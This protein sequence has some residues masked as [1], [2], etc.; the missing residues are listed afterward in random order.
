MYWTFWLP[1]T[2]VRFC[3]YKIDLARAYHQ[4][5]VNLDDIPKTAVTS[6]FEFLT[7]LFGHRNA[8]STFQR[9]LDEV[10][11]GLDF[12]FA[13]VNDILITSSTLD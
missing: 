1:C 5:T 11:H 8:A 7:M 12:I 4:I 6:P 3:F 2:A 13:Y 9:F 10:I